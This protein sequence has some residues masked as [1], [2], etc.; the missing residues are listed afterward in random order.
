MPPE[1]SGDVSGATQV[2]GCQLLATSRADVLA[3]AILGKVTQELNDHRGGVDDTAPSPP[4]AVGRCE[5]EPSEGP[6]DSAEVRIGVEMGDQQDVDVGGA[7]VLGDDSLLLVGE[8]PGHETS[9]DHEK[10]VVVA[11][12]PYEAD[13]RRLGPLP[14]G[15][16][17]L[18]LIH[19]PLGA[20]RARGEVRSVHV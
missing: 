2:D 18:A 12:L 6:L 19:G 16:R 14:S 11:Q 7:E 15:W 9:E 1:V 3:L 8:E 10:R 4:V 20:N 5:L 13:E 17:A